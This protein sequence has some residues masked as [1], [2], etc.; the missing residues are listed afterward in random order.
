MPRLARLF[1]RKVQSPYSDERLCD[2]HHVG[3]IVYEIKHVAEAAL[4]EGPTEH[5][6]VYPDDLRGIIYRASYLLNYGRS[7]FAE[8]IAE[9]S[10]EA[11][12]LNVPRIDRDGSDAFAQGRR[13]GTRDRKRRARLGFSPI[14]PP[15]GPSGE[16]AEDTGRS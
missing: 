3:L 1:R 14:L 5:M 6:R 7:P 13:D 11:A 10:M 2:P 8:G 15:E 9:G 12:G 16:N 4:E